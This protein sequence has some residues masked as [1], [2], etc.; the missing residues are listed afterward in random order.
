MIKLFEYLNLLPM[1]QTMEKETEADD[2]IAYLALHERY[3]E[4]QKVILS[5]DKDFIQLLKENETILYRPTQNDIKTVSLIL[6]E[7]DIHPNNF[8]LSRAVVGDRSD[9]L[10]R[11]LSVSGLK[12]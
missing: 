11:S 10:S 6:K 1:I 12:P 4:Y 2:I 7:Y 3:K 8:A 9:N 5:A